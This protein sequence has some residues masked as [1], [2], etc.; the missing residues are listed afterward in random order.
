MC[1]IFIWKLFLV[2]IFKLCSFLPKVSI[3]FLFFSFFLYVLDGIVLFDPTCI[4]NK[5]LFCQLILNFRYGRQADEVMGLK[6]YKEFCLESVQIYP[7][8]EKNKFVHTEVQVRFKLVLFKA[9]I[10]RQCFFYLIFLIFN[11]RNCL[12]LQYT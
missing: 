6:F 3:K 2:L 10:N 4:R 9:L 7:P 11:N 1:K 5:K 12:K 8:L